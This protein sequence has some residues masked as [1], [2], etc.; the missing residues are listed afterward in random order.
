MHALVCARYSARWSCLRVGWLEIMASRPVEFFIS[1]FWNSTVL[2][3]LVIQ[4]RM[5]HALKPEQ[6]EA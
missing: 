2:L 5:Q 3:P 6:R 1:S 4:N